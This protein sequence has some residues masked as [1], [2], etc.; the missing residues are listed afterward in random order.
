MRWW[1]KA[2]G[3]DQRS[4]LLRAV[5]ADIGLFGEYQLNP[6]FRSIKAELEDSYLQQPP[7]DEQV[8]GI[9]EARQKSERV[10]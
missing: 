8:S 9:Q 5:N 1:K 10:E 3:I 6:H 7:T 4:P 2:T